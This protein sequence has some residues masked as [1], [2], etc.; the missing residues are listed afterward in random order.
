MK[1]QRFGFSTYIGLGVVIFVM[2]VGALGYTYV[3]S[4]K[5]EIASRSKDAQS[6]T[7]AAERVTAPEV[8]EKD[9]LTESLEVLDQ[10][11]VDDLS[12]ADLNALEAE[13]ESL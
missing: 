8:K 10:A 5:A 7:I 11:S 12:E 13:L 4:N 1:R 6:K 2:L 9:D 3:M